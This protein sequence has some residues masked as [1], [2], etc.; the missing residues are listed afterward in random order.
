MQNP[1]DALKYLNAGRSRFPDDT[2]L[3]YAEINYYIKEGKLDVLIDK[4]K[5]LLKLTLKTYQFI[6]P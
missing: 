5:K 1:T 3:L 2:G 6:Q 4:L